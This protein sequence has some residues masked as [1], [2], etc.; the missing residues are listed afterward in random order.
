MPAASIAAPL[1]DSASIAEPA[2]E[3]REPSHNVGL[4]HKTVQALEIAR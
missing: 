4:Q 1:S 2:D 3:L